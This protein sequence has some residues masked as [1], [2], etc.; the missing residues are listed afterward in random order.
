LGALLKARPQPLCI[1]A[2]VIT[3]LAAIA[4]GIFQA[5]TATQHIY[6]LQNNL[7]DIQPGNAGERRTASRDPIVFSPQLAALFGHAELP[8]AETI[9]VATLPETQLN[10]RLSATFIY[11]DAAQS[12]AIIEVDGAP[13]VRLYEGDILNDKIK[14]VRITKGAMVIQNGDVLEAIT[15]TTVPVLLQ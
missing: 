11:E 2:G 12:N 15:L 10:I 5:H 3:P 1:A 7:Q 9:D 6:Q 8:Q 14:V 4:F 13:S